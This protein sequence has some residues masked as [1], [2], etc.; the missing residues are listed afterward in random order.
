MVRRPEQYDTMGMR[1]LELN[2]YYPLILQQHLAQVDGVTFEIMAVEPDS[3]KQITRLAVR[4][5]T[6]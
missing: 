2:G 1:A 5:Y 6:L 3:Q 4:V